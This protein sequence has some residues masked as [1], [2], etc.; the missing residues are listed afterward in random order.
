MKRKQYILIFALVVCVC[1]SYLSVAQTWYE[2]KASNDN[3]NG[4]YVDVLK[5]YEVMI[6]QGFS[7]QKILQKTADAYF[8]QGEYRKAYPKYRSLF[9]RYKDLAPVYYFRYAHSLKSVSRYDEAKELMQEFSVKFPSHQQFV[10]FSDKPNYVEE[11]QAKSKDY[12]IGLTAINSLEADFAPSYYKD[13][14]VFTSARDTGNFVKHRHKWNESP[15]TKLYVAHMDDRTR[16]LS[17]VNVFSK[18]L[19]T[20][21]YH[22]SS[23]AFTSDG[24]VMYFTRNNFLNKQKNTNSQGVQLLKIYRAFWKNGEWQEEEELSINS[25]NYNTAHPALSADEK[26]LYFVSDRPGG[27][28][29]SDLWKVEIF[30]DAQLGNPINLGQHINTPNRETFPFISKKGLLYFAS[31]GHLGL[32]GLDIFVAKTN[33]NNEFDQIQ[34]IGAAINSRYDDF[35]MVI[36][37]TGNG[38]FSSNRRVGRYEKDNIFRL[39][40]YFSPSFETNLIKKIRVTDETTALPIT[41]TTVKVLNAEYEQ[42]NKVTTDENGALM[43]QLPDEQQEVYLRFENE[44]YEIKEI[45]LQLEEFSNLGTLEV[46]LRKRLQEIKK[47]KDLAVILAIEEIYFDLDKYNIREDAAIELAKVLTIMK[48]YPDIT[49]EIGSHTDSRASKTYN[50]TLSQ[51]RAEATKNWLVQNGIEAQRISAKGYG[52]S[53][54]VNE[55]ADG[56]ECTE[57]KHQENRRSEFII[58]DMKN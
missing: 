30:A 41:Q 12:D 21:D 15:F 7:N 53:K 44:D 47:G 54:L 11:I 46:Q 17:Q 9:R 18:Q 45:T 35:A 33:A 49:I 14:V 24:K 19:N 42:I 2:I 58:I 1:N 40:Q 32:G 36:D 27:F 4:A 28:G 57:E 3:Q 29:M 51:N 13:K 25:D 20:S 8:F 23:T 37:S 22:E 43:L 48:A 38:F 26:T 52:E 34:N 10:A 31:D 56:V 55:C 50:N 5:V 39:K 6:Q 16:E